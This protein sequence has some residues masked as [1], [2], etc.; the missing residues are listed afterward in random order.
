MKNTIFYAIFLIA[1]LLQGC[2]NLFDEVIGDYGY[3]ELR[4]PSNLVPPGTV[5]EIKKYKP[6][7]LDIVCTQEGSLGTDFKVPESDTYN[8]ELVKKLNKSFAIGADYLRQIKGNVKLEKIKNIKLEFS[9]ATI[10]QLSADAVIENVAYRTVPCQKA[11]E[12]YLD[13]NRNVTMITSVLKADVKYHVD[14]E[15]EAGLSIEAKKEILKGLATELGISFKSSGENQI[16]GNGL[17]WGIRHE[18]IL[19]SPLEKQKI[20]LAARETEKDVSQPALTIPEN[21]RDDL[22]KFAD[23]LPQTKIEKLYSFDDWY[24]KGA[25]EFINKRYEKAINS[26]TKAL[27][28]EPDDAAAAYTH[29]YIGAAYGNQGMNDKALEEYDKS[30]KLKSDNPLPY[31]NK[32]VVHLRLTEYKKAFENLNKASEVYFSNGEYGKGINNI[33]TTL[34]TLDEIDMDPKTK[35]TIW[36]ETEQLKKHLE[37]ELEKILGGK[38]I[39]ITK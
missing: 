39:L 9:N 19:V 1:L 27:E 23:L 25:G 11:I 5:V 18:H 29:N 30:I 8:R 17:F 35:T 22:I 13:K 21:T 33:T 37:K 36:E 31:S 3:S 12:V 14:F 26:F 10:L 24:Y 34:S 6:V 38:V 32:A 2:S 28:K 20:Q 7:V 16:S 4:P 15:K